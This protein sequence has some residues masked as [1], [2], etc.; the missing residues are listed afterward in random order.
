VAVIV[1]VAAVVT[2]VVV[3]VNVALVAFAATVTEAG[4]DADALLLDSVITAPPAGAAVVSVTVPVLL[5]PPVTLVGLTDT[6]DSAAAAGLT[7]SAAVLLT[8]L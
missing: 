2:L 7:V 1:A 6:A 8:P 5:V 4:T 3:I